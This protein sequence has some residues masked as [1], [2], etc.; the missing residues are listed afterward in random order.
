MEV[1]QNFIDDVEILIAY[2]NKKAKDEAYSGGSSSY[3]ANKAEIFEE[4][5]ERLYNGIW[6][7]NHTNIINEEKLKRDPEYQELERLA[8]KFGKQLK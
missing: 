3:Y 5:L 4:I 1:D 2:Y 7:N 8:A 6:N